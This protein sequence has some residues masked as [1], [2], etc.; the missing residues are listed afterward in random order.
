[1]KTTDKWEVLVTIEETET[2]QFVASST[3]AP[4][5]PPAHG[6]TEEEAIRQFAEALSRQLQ[7]GLERTEPLQ[8][9]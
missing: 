1:M 2:G 7:Q 3:D 4:E 5:L 9:S 6:A 8:P